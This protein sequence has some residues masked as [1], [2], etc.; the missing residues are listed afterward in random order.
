MYFVNKKF[1]RSIDVDLGFVLNFRM[2]AALSRRWLRRCMHTATAVSS[3]TQ[4]QM[5]AWRL[6]SFTGV[7]SAS[8]DVVPV[9]PLSCPND[10]LVQVKAASVNPLDLMMA[11]GYGD[12]AFRAYR[13]LAAGRPDG[14]PL[15]LGRDFSGVV[16]D[17]GMNSGPYRIGDEVWG[18]VFPATHH[19]THAE[20]VTASQTSVSLKPKSLS[21]VQAA[22]VPYA[23]LTAWG[24]LRVTAE[25]GPGTAGSQVLV[26]GA[27]GGVGTLAVQL[28]KSWNCNVV[29][30]CRD[31]AFELVTGLG[32][33]VVLDY[34]SSEFQSQMD[35]LS[36]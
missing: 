21:H 22:S 12:E 36:G 7:N 16:V 19:G 17:V 34:Q 20:Y 1:P 9:P 14:L 27:S 25:L 15:T 2:A 33:D 23:G 5:K 18:T 28:L 24:G 3:E 4:V 29:A 30:T 13:T 11:K 10:L 26:V 31:D 32:A 8:L 35:R 6:H